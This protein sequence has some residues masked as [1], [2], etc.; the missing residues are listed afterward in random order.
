MLKI[1]FK[2]LHKDAKIPVR[3]TKQ[4][5]ATD[6]YCTEINYVNDYKVWCKLGF[7]AQFPDTHRMVIVPRSNLTKTNWIIQ[8]SPGTGDADYTGEYEVRFIRVAQEYNIDGELI[9]EFPYKV[10][11]R[12][13]QCYFERIEEEE[14]EEV[15]ELDNTE[16]VGGFGSTGLN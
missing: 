8:N 13:A 16:R 6:L 12:I 14:W 7:A 11:D 15:N 1:K 5:G 4:A 10:G 3:A 9:K 2:R